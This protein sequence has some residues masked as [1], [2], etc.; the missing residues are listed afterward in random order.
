MVSQCQAASVLCNARAHELLQLAKVGPTWTLQT[1]GHCVVFK[2]AMQLSAPL[3]ER[4]SLLS[5]GFIETL[6]FLLAVAVAVVVAPAPLLRSPL[7][8]R[9]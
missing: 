6:I 4:E 7:H 9:I 1:D 3:F 5:H 2:T 8:P